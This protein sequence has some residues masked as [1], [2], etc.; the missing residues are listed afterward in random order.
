MTRS[1]IVSILGSLAL[2]LCAAAQAQNAPASSSTLTAGRHEHLTAAGHLYPA[3]F[4][5]VLRRFQHVDRHA[6]FRGKGH[7]EVCERAAVAQAEVQGRR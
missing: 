1:S 3:F 6:Q 7:F 4:E 2:V 5:R